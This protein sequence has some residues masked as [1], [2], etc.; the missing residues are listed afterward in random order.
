MLCTVSSLLAQ[1]TV[2]AAAARMCVLNEGAVALCDVV[3]SLDLVCY[4][5]NPRA[6]TCPYYCDILDTA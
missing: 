4:G 2:L 5:Y 6:W 3:S 1:T